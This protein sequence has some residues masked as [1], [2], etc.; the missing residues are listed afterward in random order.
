MVDVLAKLLKRFPGHANQIRCVAHIV[1]LVVK[2]ILRQFDA[3]KKTADSEYQFVFE[4]G[5]QLMRLDTTA[6]EDEEH[7]NDFEE[8]VA[9]DDGADE[10]DDDL[11]EDLEEVEKLMEAE[12]KK[13]AKQVK[14]IRRVLSRVS[15]QRRL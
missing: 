2:L 15:V 13:L 6:D 5:K 9:M 11:H 4:A 14:P 3:P 1:N 7:T 8:E 12:V 10:D